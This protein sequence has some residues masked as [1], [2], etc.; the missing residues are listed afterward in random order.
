MVGALIGPQ[1]QKVQW[2]G[3]SASGHVA[4]VYYE[5]DPSSLSLRAV[6]GIW[7]VAVTVCPDDRIA[8]SYQRHPGASYGGPFDYW[9]KARSVREAVQLVGVCLTRPAV[10]RKECARDAGLQ[11]GLKTFPK[12]SILFPFVGLGAGWRTPFRHERS[13]FEVDAGETV[14]IGG[15][16]PAATKWTETAP[17]LDYTLKVSEGDDG[18]LYVVRTGGGVP[19]AVAV[20]SKATARSAVLAMLAT[21]T[22]QEL[23]EG[24]AGPFGAAYGLKRWDGELGEALTMTPTR[25]RRLEQG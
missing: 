25:R 21:L 22:F 18:R 5:L 23:K 4:H 12:T 3:Y 2:S 17:V 8:V 19:Q 14:T 15:A 6:V 11:P 13:L 20:A 9:M 10:M 1:G 24:S 7:E 16:P